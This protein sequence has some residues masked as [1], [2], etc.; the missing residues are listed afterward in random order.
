MRRFTAYPPLSLYVHFP[1]CIKK[2]PYCDFNSHAV[3]DEIP[4]SRYLDTLITELEQRVP[5]IWGRPVESIFFGGGTPSLLSADGM[6][7]LLGK[8]RALVKLEPDAEVTLEANPGAVDQARFAAYHACGINRLSIGIQSFTDKHLQTLGRVHNSQ[9]AFAACEA[10]QSAG[11]TNFNIDL[12]HGLPEQSA[13]DAI[14]DIETALSLAP[15]HLS[16]YQLTIEPNTLFA[17]KPP[18]LPDDDALWEIQQHGKQRLHDAGFEQYEVSAYA[19]SGRQCRHNLNYWRF[20]DYLGIGAGAHSKLT[21]PADNSIVR[22]SNI[23][24]PDA[25]MRATDCE[26]R[27]QTQQLVA[28]VDTRLEF[29]M[30]A[31]RLNEGFAAEEFENH[32]GEPLSVLHKQLG[33]AESLGLLTR[34]ITRVTPTA[35]GLRMLNSLLQLF[36]TDSPEYTGGKRRVSIPIVAADDHGRV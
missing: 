24:H 30:N 18:L 26:Q 17:A 19:A 33:H 2:C 7:R 29:M 6:D 35:D 8:I 36:L 3:R 12:I 22:H 21:F 20:G 14:T 10:A 27:T 11:F 28:P 4:E 34:D 31:L 23:K 32:C 15:T 5:D 25:F 1:W 9:Q 16:Y 13:D